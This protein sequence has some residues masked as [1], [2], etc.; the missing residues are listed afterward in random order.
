LLDPPAKLLRM[1]DVIMRLQKLELLPQDLRVCQISIEKSIRGG[2]IRGK[3]AMI[4]HDRVTVRRHGMV[5][6]S[7]VI[8]RRIHSVLQ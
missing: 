6:P 7:D 5:K 2:V 8:Q 3:N 4:V 1:N